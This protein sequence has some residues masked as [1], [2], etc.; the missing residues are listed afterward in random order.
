MPARPGI[1]ALRTEKKDH[2]FMA[3]KDGKTFFAPAMAAFLSKKEALP[4]LIFLGALIIR[5]IDLGRRPFW[6]DEVFT[7]QRASL[8]RAALVHDSF[9]NHHIPS[10]FLMLSPLVALGNPQFWLRVPSA[11]FGAL[12]VMMV[13]LIGTRIA[14]RTAG[15]AAALILGLSP[16][17][18]AFSQEARSYT[19]EMSLILVAL[20]GIAILAT[21]IPAA[22]ASWRVK[23]PARPGWALFIFGSAAAL[24]VLGDGLPW[25]ITANIIAVFLF[26][27][28][29]NRKKLCRNFL[30][31]DA[32]ITALSAPFYII[33]SLTQDKGFV[34]SV[35]WI[36][37]L[38]TSRLWYDIAS[39]YLMRVADA[40][41]FRL[42]DVSTPHTLMWLIDCG[43]I[44]ALA[45]GA[46]TLRRRPAILAAIGLS[47][48]ILPICLVLISIWRPIL[49]PRYMLW[50][51]APFAILAGIGAGYILNT[52]NPRRR[53][54]AFTAIAAVLLV[55]LIPYYGAETKPRWD[56]A[57]K[58][59]AHEMAPGDVL[60]L[61]DTGALP[62]LK[63]YLPPGTDTY[64]LQDSDGD[65]AHAR[66]AQLA[67][68]RVWAV[69]GRAGQGPNTSPEIAAA[70]AKLAPLGTPTEF[71]MAGGRIYI[72]MFD[73][74]SLALSTN[75]VVPPT[76]EPVT[77]L[78]NSPCG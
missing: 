36:P 43:L 61:S 23:S 12:A 53:V 56:I 52:L 26:R 4:G 25:V 6:L 54:A 39:I 73:P 1:H 22:S 3:P 58:M 70:Y 10:F 65:V 57:A 47:F 35:M 40:V 74:A 13:Y 71:E 77:S 29:P 41:T 18:L 20:Y 8:P 42:M 45:I 69:I 62:I 50:S 21:D 51:A 16:A 5:L 60:V 15:L 68:K 38:S 32:I 19:M 11:A 14:G 64:V 75:C 30:A 49:L 44:A 27:Q 33:M 31:A 17:A 28:S 2:L 48:A 24:D 34:D 55:N 59:L 7:M 63:M 67:G 37:P 66:Q 76:T 72:N 46:W 78:P 9:A